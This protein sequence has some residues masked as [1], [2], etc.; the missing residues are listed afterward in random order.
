MESVI[1]MSSLPAMLKKKLEKSGGVRR[2]T[3]TRKTC[4]RTHRNRKTCTHRNR[5]T[6]TRKK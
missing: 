2:K 4:T 6:R 1:V 5:K 3:C